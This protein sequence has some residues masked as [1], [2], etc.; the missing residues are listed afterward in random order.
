M[1][2]KTTRDTLFDMVKFIAVF[3]WKRYVL[4]KADSP[5]L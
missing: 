2:A 4:M 1:V 5:F 3:I